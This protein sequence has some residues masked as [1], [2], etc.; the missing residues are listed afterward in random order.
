LNNGRTFVNSATGRTG[1]QTVGK[2][3]KIIQPASP[4]LPPDGPATSA[5][6]GWHRDA[7]M[8]QLPDKSSADRQ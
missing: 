4:A 1:L 6:D 2:K 5:S 8:H 3:Q 7:A